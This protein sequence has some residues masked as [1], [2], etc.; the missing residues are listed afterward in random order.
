[1]TPATKIT[2][3]SVPNCRNLF[4]FEFRVDIVPD[5]ASC[6]RASDSPPGQHAMYISMPTRQNIHRIVTCA[7]LGSSE[8]N[9]FDAAGGRHEGPSCRGLLGPREGLRARGCRA[10]RRQQADRTE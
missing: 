9:I 5:L 4:I 7:R 8:I 10:P 2:A 3:I 6:R 1:M